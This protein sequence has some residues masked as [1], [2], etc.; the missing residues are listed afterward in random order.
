VETA[1]GQLDESLRKLHQ[2]SEVR[3]AAEAEAA[4]LE[5]R[6][7]ELETR[8]LSSR[9]LWN[10][11][12]DAL[13]EAERRRDRASSAFDLLR[14]QISLDSTPASTRWPTSSR[15]GCRG[16]RV[17]G[18]RVARLADQIEKIGPVNVLAIEEHQS[19][20]S[21]SRSSAPSATIWCRPSS[22]CAAPSARST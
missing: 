9:E 7:Q 2:L 6:V 11:A 14:E 20:S 21:A 16:A 12:K 17:A 19:S 18:D 15:V 10:T 22:R 8:A 1:R 4:D 13:F 5:A 3:I